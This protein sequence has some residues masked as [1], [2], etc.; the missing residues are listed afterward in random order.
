MITSE[1]ITDGQRMAASLLKRL[2]TEDPNTC[3]IAL[4]TCL[5]MASK[6]AGMPL[7][8]VFTIL[9]TIDVTLRSSQGDAAAIAQ[10]AMGNLGLVK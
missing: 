2:G 5:M 10:Q 7:K 9:D 3:V 4:A 6:G 1:N 8:A